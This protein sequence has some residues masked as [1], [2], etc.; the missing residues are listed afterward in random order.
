VHARDLGQEQGKAVLVSNAELRKF[1]IS[2]W[3]F[4]FQRRHDDD[5]KDSAPVG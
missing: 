3:L 1:G 4:E 2:E 5:D